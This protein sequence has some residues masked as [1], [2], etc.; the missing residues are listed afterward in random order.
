M[1]DVTLILKDGHYFEGPRWHDGR[2]WV[3]DFFAHKVYSTNLEGDVRV[4]AEVPNRPSGL[5]W[6]PDGRLLI[7]S[8]NDQKILRREENGELSVHAD[9]SELAGGHQINDMH[10]DQRGHA[11]VG[12]MGFNPYVGDPVGPA[13]L[14]HVAP[15]GSADVAAT[16]LWMPNG[17]AMLPGPVLLVGENLGNCHTA[18]DVQEDGSLT[19]RRVWASYGPRTTA[20]DVMGAVMTTDVGT[21]GCAADAERALWVADAFHGR[22]IRVKDGEIVQQIPVRDLGEQGVF[23]VALGG[24]DGRTLF[25]CTAPDYDPAARSAANESKVLAIKVDVPGIDFA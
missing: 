18:F 4:E 9:L 16:D 12:S 19:N 7:S 1:L 22:L 23:A 11:Y 25:I 8:M 21:D 10:V 5:G 3:S 15:A 6:L 20:T 17:M 24:T 2:L 14:L 13:P